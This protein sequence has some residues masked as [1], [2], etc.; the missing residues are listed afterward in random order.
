MGDRSLRFTQRH[1]WL[2]R[3]GILLGSLLTAE[4]LA[5]WFVALGW[6][7]YQ[8]NSISRD[9]QFWEDLNP[10]WGVWH[11]SD[12]EFRHRAGCFD[13]TYRTNEH[14]MRDVS[15]DKPSDA[16]RRVVMLGDS[17]L[18]GIGM[19][20]DQR[21]SNLLEDATGVE[22]LN[23]GT[24]CDFGAVQEYLLY[25]EFAKTFD[26]TEV[27]IFTLP[28]NDA[29]DN[30]P[31][32]FPPRRFRPYVIESSAGDLES[33]YPVAFDERERVHRQV[34]AVIRNAITNNSYLFNAIRCLIRQMKADPPLGDPSYA[35]YTEF[36]QRAL[37]Y[38]YERLVE[39]AAGRTVHLVTIPSFADIE[40]AL[41]GEKL[42]L[43]D[44]IAAFAS[45]FENAHYTDLMPAYVADIRA[46]GR[47]LID[48]ILPCDGHPNALAH[49]VIA[50][51]VMDATTSR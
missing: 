45:R 35:S 15:R 48:Y 26:H 14:G 42:P 24:A 43:P 31:E 13:V 47:D 22:H 30:R 39:A 16:P 3:F 38:C 25:R 51:A 8:Y 19:E 41:A 17:M 49:R 37:L 4:A 34:G 44:V 20:R 1:P 29:V 23:F 28:F 6:L 7:P 40:A 33:H 46:S 5:R 50:D 11:Y 12:T 18:E 2:T 9:P 10:V 21:F 32:A 36:D 27:Q